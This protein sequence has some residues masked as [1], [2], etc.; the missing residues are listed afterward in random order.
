MR[1]IRL[2]LILFLLCVAAQGQARRDIRSARISASGESTLETKLAGTTIRVVV[3]T[4][5][6]D[7]GG[8]IATPPATGTA[9]TN[10]TYSRCPCSQVRN[11][12]IWVGDKRL[13]VPR[14]VFADSTDL[15]TMSLAFK[16]GTS[17][18]TLVGG[19]ASESYS[20]KVY[21]DRKGV[22]KREIYD[23]ESNSLLEETTYLTP[24]VLD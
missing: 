12:A 5:I 15:G 24:P 11:I 20:L 6:I 22:K 18:L 1:P 3:S 13:F 4:Y 8:Y 9:Q 7:L 21:F 2:Y 19:D 14:S 10:C 17:I 16:S 23:L